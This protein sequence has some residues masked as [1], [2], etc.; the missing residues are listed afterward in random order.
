[1]RALSKQLFPLDD[2]AVSK[3][4][5]DVDCR[6]LQQASGQTYLVPSKHNKAKAERFAARMKRKKRK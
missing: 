4:P 3:A 2:K 6:A 5:R 1:M